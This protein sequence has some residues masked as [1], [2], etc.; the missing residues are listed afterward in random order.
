MKQEMQKK[1]DTLSDSIRNLQGRID[2]FNAKTDQE[3][4]DALAE[5]EG[6]C[7]RLSEEL[8]L[9]AGEEKSKAYAELLKT[10]MSYRQKKEELKADWNRR[11][12][13]TQKAIARQEAIDAAE[14]ADF[15]VEIANY[16]A[17][18]AYAA[19]IDAQRQK[20]KFEEE[21]GESLDIW[22]T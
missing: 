11:K 6:E 5:A 20:M 18:E 4:E 21:F 13:T 12:V 14:Y 7:N 2:L 3:L 1:L 17:Q 22:D 15:M 16:A 9:H 19:V 10:Q 8:R